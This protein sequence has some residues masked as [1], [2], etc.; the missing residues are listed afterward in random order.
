MGSREMTLEPHVPL[1]FYVV[2]LSFLSLWLFVHSPPR[3]RQ[4][5]VSP[6]RPSDFNCFCLC[7]IHL[8]TL[9][10]EARVEAG[11]GCERSVSLRR[12]LGSAHSE[13]RQCVHTLKFHLAITWEA[14]GLVIGL[15]VAPR[16]TCGVA[17]L[18]LSLEQ[19]H[20][21]CLQKHWVLNFFFFCHGA[22]IGWCHRHWQHE[23]MPVVSI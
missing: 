5:S 10:Q 21:T 13:A 20:G 8:C 18:T 17:R 4:G 22:V 2:Q 16:G 23:E 3:S 15:P 7:F 11:T 14:C 1:H 6:L 9:I 12:G 19:S